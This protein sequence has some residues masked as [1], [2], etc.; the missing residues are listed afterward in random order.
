MPA[1]FVFKVWSLM[2]AIDRKDEFG[3]KGSKMGIVSLGFGPQASRHKVING[4]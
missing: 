2:T 3:L 1:P 4:A